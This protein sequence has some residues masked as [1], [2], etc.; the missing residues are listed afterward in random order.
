MKKNIFFLL[1]LLGMNWPVVASDLPKVYLHLDNT[2][3]TAGDYIWFKA[4]LLDGVTHKP[5]TGATNLYVELINSRGDLLKKQ[6]HRSENGISWGDFKLSDSIPDGNYMIRAYTNPMR[7]MGE[8][9]LFN[10]QIY[11]SNPHFPKYVRTREVIANRAFNRQLLRKSRRL[12]LHFFPEGGQLVRGLPVR[13]AFEARDHLGRSL[14]AEGA[15][16]NSRGEPVARFASSVAGRGYVMFNPL[17]TVGYTAR[18][19][20]QGSRRMQTFNLPPVRQEGISMRVDKDENEFVVQ[21]AANSHRITREGADYMLKAHSGG[22]MLFHTP[23]VFENGRT[24]ASIPADLLYPG[25]SEIFVVSP[26]KE[27]MSRRMVFVPESDK[28]EV[29]V[30]KVRWLDG[31]CH[32]EIAIDD[33]QSF[34]LSGSYSLSVKAMEGEALRYMEPGGE[35]RS[36]VLLESELG[37]A[38]DGAPFLSGLEEGRQLDSMDL[39][40]MTSRWE[41]M[42]LQR[43][44]SGEPIATQ[45]DTTYG[46][47]IAG[48]LIHPANDKPVTGHKVNLIV[49]NGFVE[50]F[51]TMTDREGA[52]E[53]SGLLYN[54]VVTV[55]LS[56]EELTEGYLP[57]IHL[58][59]GQIQASSFLP[60]FTT[61]PQEVTRKSVFWKRVKRRDES[62]YRI[63]EYYYPSQSYYGQ[64]SQ[65]I[66]VSEMEDDYRT[67]LDV[68]LQRATG[69]TYHQGRLIMRG[70]SSVM[71]SNEPLFILDG[72]AADRGTFLNT[73]ARDVHRIEIF[74]GASAVIFG[75]RGTNGAIVAYT[76]RGG[77]YGRPTYEFTMGGFYIPREFSPPKAGNTYWAGRNEHYT[78]TLFWN[79]DIR[80]TPR[81]TTSFS[82]APIEGIDQYMINIQGVGANGRI[83]SR[84][85][86]LR[87][88]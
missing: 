41:R 20:I 29:E 28:L 15:I 27:V 43:I 82:F 80:P 81:S 37:R 16:I 56:A 10:R 62:P 66:Y 34:P 73:S 60:D 69:L 74:R 21:M 55:E 75:M 8:N 83:S 19:Q 47:T 85:I 54:G 78:P 51:S 76:R 59:I 35:V 38:V 25:V 65:T 50:N 30:V 23:I 45:F 22:E 58:D 12:E 2:Y 40:M 1:L 49:R 32:V 39:L 31:Q 63:P 72:N 53:F 33:S 3:Y 44:V 70:V 9:Y 88:H 86:I 79:P 7:E 26:D 17:D 87:R 52:F 84:T 11:I 71:F 57:R 36:F 14:P 5:G 42:N 18:I 13:L 46:M 6:M 4:Y 24:S 61:R 77:M 48:Q 67:V 64:P 68:L